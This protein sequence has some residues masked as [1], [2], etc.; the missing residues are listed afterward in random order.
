MISWYAPSSLLSW[1][2]RE[3]ADNRARI[4]AKVDH[5]GA[6][7]VYLKAS[8]RLYESDGRTD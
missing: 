5:P 6:V 1:K 3:S 7:T 2:K 4:R 8:V